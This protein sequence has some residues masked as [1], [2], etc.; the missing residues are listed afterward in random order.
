MVDTIERIS[1]GVVPTTGPRVRRRIDANPETG[2]FNASGEP[3]W[4]EIEGDLTVGQIKTLTEN[5]YW[6][7]LFRL[8]A[9]HVHGWNAEDHAEAFED[10]PPV[11]D[12]AGREIVPARRV[13]VAG[14]LEAVPPPATGGPDAFLRVDERC[15]RWVLQRLCRLPVELTPDQKKLLSRLA[16]TPDGGHDATPPSPPAPSSPKKNRSSTTPAS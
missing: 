4:I 2:P 6:Y 7:D 11:L 8:M 10:A 1:N 14:E 16:G 13:A 15:R 3:F 9:P 5:T 12:A